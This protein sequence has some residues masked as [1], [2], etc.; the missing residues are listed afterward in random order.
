MEGS[1][2][3]GHQKHTAST[4]KAYLGK[5]NNVTLSA[6]DWPHQ[7]LDLNITETMW[8]HLDKEHYKRQQTSKEEMLKRS[9]RRGCVKNKGDH[10]KYTL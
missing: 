10:T 4:V 7:K 2:D 8:D 3:R 5:E 1:G 9:L 6:M